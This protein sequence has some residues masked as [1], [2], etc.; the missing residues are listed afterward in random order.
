MYWWINALQS[1]NLP[2]DAGLNLNGIQNSFPDAQ[3]KITWAGVSSAAWPS[4]N[5]F[6]TIPFL[7]SFVLH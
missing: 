1:L 2:I 5:A 3:P 4:H 7:T 6:S